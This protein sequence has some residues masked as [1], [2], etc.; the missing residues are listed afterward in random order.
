MSTRCCRH[1]HGDCCQQRHPTA[2]DFVIH[3]VS[4]V[5]WFRHRNYKDLVRSRAQQNTART[6][7]SASTHFDDLCDA[8]ETT[9][10]AQLPLMSTPILLTDAKRTELE[11]ELEE[12]TTIR[13]PEVVSRIA[14]TRQEGDLK[15]NAGYHQAR[16][17]QSRLEGRINEITH[18]LL[19]AVIIETGSSDG[20]IRAGVRVT[21]RDSDGDAI[22]HVVGPVEADPSA[23]RIS[24][25]SPVGR[26]LLG[27]K[28][29][30]VVTVESPSG[31]RS[32]TVID[33]T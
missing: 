19:H 29:G 31:A 15:E 27:H 2:H 30:D 12:L 21:V 9:F 26:A 17:D 10:V 13:R 11:Q 33:V 6:L 20:V 32:L 24:M 23:G 5:R 25:E 8:E 7:G 22:Y 16:E 4:P 18:I 3:V 28:K 1:A 14:T